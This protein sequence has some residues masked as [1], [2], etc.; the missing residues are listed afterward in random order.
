MSK[1]LQV[2][3]SKR[4]AR[5]DERYACTGCGSIVDIPHTLSPP[6]GICRCPKCVSQT[7]SHAFRDHYKETFGHE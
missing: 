3:R 7:A 4:R 2:F 5:E 6:N 1:W